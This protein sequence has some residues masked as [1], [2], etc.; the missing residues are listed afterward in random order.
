VTIRPL[1]QIA[2]DF[3]PRETELVVW[4]TRAFLLGLAGHAWL[5]VAVRSFYAQQNA[6]TPFLAAL[7]QAMSYLLLAAWLARSVGHTGLALADTLTFSGQ[8][9]LLLWLLNR[10]YPGALE[11]RSTLLRGSLAALAAGALAYVLLRFAP[12]PLLPLTAGAL[13]AGGLIALPFIWTEVKSLAR[14]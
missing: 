8:A 4:A 7:L 3:G 6:R 13:A 5:E 9:L 11:V 14:L 12:L 2:F 10:R 1:V